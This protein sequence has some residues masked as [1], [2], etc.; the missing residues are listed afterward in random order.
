MDARLQ[1]IHGQRPFFLRQDDLPVVARALVG[2][3]IGRVRARTDFRTSIPVVL[4]EGFGVSVVIRQEDWVKILPWL[5]EP[6]F[7]PEPMTRGARRFAFTSTRRD[8]PEE[9]RDPL[10]YNTILARLRVIFP[11]SFPKNE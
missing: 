6:S 3:S 9:L 11:E 10:L 4:L 8:A 5:K 2:V 1:Q 7:Y